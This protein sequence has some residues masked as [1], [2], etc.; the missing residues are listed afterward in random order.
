MKIG[1][2]GFGLVDWGGGR[3]MLR[4]FMA[5]LT[6]VERSHRLEIAVLLPDTTP[7]WPADLDAASLAAGL[8]RPG[9][10]QL[11]KRVRWALQARKEG[12]RELDGLVRELGLSA[13][14][15][16]RYRACHGLPGLRKACTSLR[17]DALVACVPHLGADF[18]VPWCGYLP[19][20][21]HRRLPHMFEQG[22]VERRDGHFAATLSNADAMIATSLAV[23][24]DLEQFFGGHPH[25][26]VLP[27]A[28][29]PVVQPGRPAA[30]RAAARFGIE[31]PY[32]IICNQF[33]RH[34]DHETAFRAF[35]A[36][37]HS[38][39]GQGV[40]LVCTGDKGD[41][42]HQDHFARM[43]ALLDELAIKQHVRIL[44]RIPKE[45]Q[46]ALLSAAVALVQ[47]SLF[48]GTRGGLAVADALALAR[49]C[50][51]SD[52]AVN[53][54]LDEPGVCFF[55]VGDHDDLAQKMRAVLADPPQT[56]DP[57]EQQRVCAER[58]RALGERLVD[59]ATAAVAARRT[60]VA[61][62]AEHSSSP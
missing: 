14:G 5:A 26:A 31:G 23:A 48:E 39:T 11:A 38:A 37:R 34:K 51:V 27:M 25:C 20:V 44:G 54:E 59:A 50:V 22:E 33:W 32:F 24:D 28:W 45:D 17:L 56:R 40:T 9:A 18:P 55:K 3:D 53:R 47:P 61:L 16:I 42:R 19:D 49:P 57:V 43:S 2:L 62:R 7:E 13:P 46:L 15:S 21:Q 36:I 10:L 4:Q 8:V 6:A 30:V 1:L 52:I 35:A 41:Y 29:L 58:L 60:R 12:T